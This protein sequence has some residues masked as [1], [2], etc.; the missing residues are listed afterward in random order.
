MEGSPWNS[1]AQGGD[2]GRGW[3][4]HGS[5]ALQEQPGCWPCRFAPLR[6][7]RSSVHPS[8]HPVHPSIH[9]REAPQPQHSTTKTTHRTPADVQPHQSMDPAQQPEPC[10]AKNG[11]KRDH[12]GGPC[13]PPRG[14]SHTQALPFG[15]SNT[16]SN[17]P[18]H[19]MLHPI[20]T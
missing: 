19:T 11:E 15:G 1:K 8:T 3:S 14:T 13:P 5:S 16:M 6:R 7:G 17:P 18:K 12:P 10:T 4:C 9:T 2:L 20:Y